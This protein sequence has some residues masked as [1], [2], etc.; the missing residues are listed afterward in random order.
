MSPVSVLGGAEVGERGRVEDATLYK[1]V[2]GRAIT[3]R[4]VG[5]VLCFGFVVAIKYIITVS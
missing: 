4:C 3:L 1:A 2:W 5:F